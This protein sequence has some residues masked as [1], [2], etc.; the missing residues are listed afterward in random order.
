MTAGAAPLE[1]EV[2]PAWPFRLRPRVGGDGVAR[3]R[4][5]VVS[6]LLA[7]PGGRVVVHVWQ[8][9]AQRVVFRA[10]PADP[11][12]PAGPE[13][14]A[15]AIERMRFAVG[16]DEDMTEF[17]RTFRGD[18]LIG[19]IIHHRPWHRPRRRPWPWEALAWAVTEQLIESSR[20]AEIQRRVVRRWGGKLMPNEDGPCAWLGPGPLRDVPSAEV[21]AGVAP[22][23]LAAFDLAPSRAIALIHCAR[24]V[25]RG[26]VDPA[27]AE[28]DRRLARIPGIGPWTLQVLG[29]HGRGEPDSLPAGDLAY[30]KLVG[31]L[32]GLGRRAT[33]EE[34]E[35]YFAP[36]APFRGLAGSFALARWHGSVAAGPPLRLAA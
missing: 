30:V 3:R 23:E 26:R 25:A 28:G 22:A 14:L 34:V 15:L 33:V 20:A 6:R 35:E 13:A 12:C 16:V 36:Y 9:Q 2:R 29:F 10:G 11:D 1:V 19:E 31:S 32:A 21:I 4:G 24:E 5:S 18:P 27:R 7:T 17:A 8:P